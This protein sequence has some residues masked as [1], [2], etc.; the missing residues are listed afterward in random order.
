MHTLPHLPY[1]YNALEPVIDTQTMQIHHTRHHQIYIDKLNNWLS[2]YPSHE[3]LSATELLSQ[4]D[5]LPDI[6][7]PVVRNHGWWH[8]NHSL[9]WK[10]MCNQSES[11]QSKVESKKIMEALKTVFWSF[12]NFVEQFTTAALNQFGSGWAWLVKNNEWALSIIATSNQDS[13]LMQWLTPILGLDVREHA[14]Y[15]KYQNKRP[16]YIKAWFSIINRKEVEKNLVE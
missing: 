16:D 14:Y 6:L 12:E 8:A 4:F 2:T 5:T 1:D 7:K 15:L 3:W 13:P 9:F 10:I 11:E